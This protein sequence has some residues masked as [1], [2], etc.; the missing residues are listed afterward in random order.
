[1]TLYLD[2]FEQIQK[3]IQWLREWVI[4]DEE[5]LKRRLDRSIEAKE[6]DSYSIS[7]EERIHDL[8]IKLDIKYT[9]RDTL[10]I[11][12]LSLFNDP[13]VKEF[14]NASN[15]PEFWES[16]LCVRPEGYLLHE[17]GLSSNV[18]FQEDMTLFKRS[19]SVE[20]RL[21]NDDYHIP[22]LRLLVAL[23]PEN[24]ITISALKYS[25]SNKHHLLDILFGCSC[26]F[27][28]ALM[29]LDYSNYIDI[30]EDGIKHIK[31]KQN[32]DGSWGKH[33]HYDDMHFAI[34]A[35]SRINGI[36][37]DYIK[38][39]IEF[40]KTSQN[41]DGSWGEKVSIFPEEPEKEPIYV[42]SVDNTSYALL[43][44][45][46]V[47]PPLS[48]TQEQYQL[49]KIQYEQK[50]NRK[51]SD[52]IHTSPLYDTKDKI[53]HVTTLH[54]KISEVL[55]NAKHTLLIMSPYIDMH[56]KE[57]TNLS[58][59]N[60]LLDIRIITRPKDEIGGERKKISK[61]AINLLKKATKGKL[62]HLDIIHSRLI[63]VDNQEIILSSADLTLEGLADEFNA[64]IYTRDPELVKQSIDYFENT[65]N[66][67]DIV[68]KIKNEKQLEY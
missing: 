20:G 63:I 7:L 10:P 38:R 47:T 36:Y 58:A 44:L 50:I 56:Y 13:I 59:R 55:N 1:M 45:L 16:E 4:F 64:G 62:K 41:P 25:L 17:M 51:K 40:I 68:A 32:Q 57:I 31:G 18:F 54:D 53:L 5:K 23:E 46:A 9:S 26:I 67:E 49:E 8:E 33:K 19:R 21:S 65:W 61:H 52:F 37:N 28:L 11:Y 27:I 48:I 15:S 29:E 66:Y 35:I 2:N 43:S 34:K 24:S 30:I 42:H 12:V 39:S 60:P 6:E 14:K 3:G 22:L